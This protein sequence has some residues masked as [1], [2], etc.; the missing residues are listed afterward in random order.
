MARQIHQ[1]TKIVHDVTASREPAKLPHFG[2]CYCLYFD[3][4][5]PP[6][7]E[8]ITPHVTSSPP[9]SAFSLVANGAGGSAHW[10]LDSHQLCL[11]IGRNSI[12]KT[13]LRK[14]FQR[15]QP[16]HKLYE[17]VQRQYKWNEY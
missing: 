12:K 10:G 17:N 15:K 8:S 1:Q 6:D 14:Q 16:K 13:P 5:E 2:G 7:R 11:S 4:R 9:I 3:G